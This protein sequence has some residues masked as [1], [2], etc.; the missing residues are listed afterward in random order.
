MAKAIIIGTGNIGT[1]LQT[2][3]CKNGHE[4][5]ARASR[6]KVWSKGEGPWSI[7]DVGNVK[8]ITSTLKV[9]GPDADAIMITIPNANKGADELEYIQRFSD[10]IV[11]TCAKAA[12]AYQY[13]HVRGLR[14]GRRA[15]VGAGT[16]MLETLRRRQ[17]QNENLIIYAVINGTLNYIWSIIQ[18]GGNFAT[19]ISDAKEL[20]FAEPNNDDPIAIL[21]GELDDV[22]MKG[23][24]LKNIALPC[25]QVLSA[26]DF[27][28]VPLTEDDIPRLTSRN[29]R[30]RFLVTISSVKDVD[31]IPKGAPGSIRVQC[32]RWKI[33]GGFHDIRAESPWYDWLRQIDGVNNGFTIHNSFGKDTGNSLGG[34]GAGPEVTAKAMVRDLHDLLAA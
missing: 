16:D 27:E 13:P 3:L 5:V 7:K 11:V 24:S 30:H 12:H 9:I 18:T 33:V 19:A 2:E 34:P 15:I 21:N 8:E 20:K 28:I 17:L 10:K 6:H 23:T 25:D 29:A 1:A 14:I 4:V 22:C 31:E 32:G 26:D